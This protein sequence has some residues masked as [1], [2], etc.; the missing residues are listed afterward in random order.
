[1]QFNSKKTLLTLAIFSGMALLPLSCN[2]VD[3][4]CNSSCGCGSTP[5]VTDFLIQDFEIQT[6]Q[7]NGNEADSE[8]FYPFDQLS[9][10]FTLGEVE[11]LALETSSS[12]NGIPGLA[13]ACSIAPPKS[14]NKLKNIQIFNTEEVMLESGDVL[15]VGDN[16]SH[17]FGLNYYH[18]QGLE[19]IAD[20]I[21]NGVEIYLD[22]SFKLQFQNDP[23]KEL[24]LSFSIQIQ[25]DGGQEFNY[26][27][28]VLRIN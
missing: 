26:Q 25:L 10:V 15:K 23:K 8:S 27:N 7:S 16:I 22:D 13:F 6:L 20:F 28:E 1:M 2:I 14:A 11:Y 5:T 19:S 17:L 3:P 21:E 4:F 24:K 18:N 9:K 12:S